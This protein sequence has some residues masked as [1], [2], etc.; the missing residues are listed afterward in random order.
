MQRLR[1]GAAGVAVQ[2]TLHPCLP[3]ASSGARRAVPQTS[4]LL[5][6]PQMEK[7]HLK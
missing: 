2:V 3:V 6:N 7:W 5:P 1:R 4:S